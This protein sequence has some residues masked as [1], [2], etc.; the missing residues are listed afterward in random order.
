[1]RQKTIIH[2]LY[3]REM[4]EHKGQWC[5]ESKTVLLF[6]NNSH[7]FCKIK[8]YISSCYT[9][10]PRSPTMMK[11]QEHLELCGLSRDLLLVQP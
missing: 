10:G 6:V 9:I 1:M 11:T 2:K 8:N 7:T 5:R 4:D 3:C